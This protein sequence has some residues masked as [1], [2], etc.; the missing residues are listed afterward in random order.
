MRIVFMGTP[1]FAV[2]SLKEL[3]NSKN[4]ICAVVTSPD[5]PAGRGLQLKES[6]VKKFAKTINVPI[7]QPTNLKDIN[8][9]NELKSYNADIFVVVAFRMLPEIVW[10]IPPKGTINLHASLL[11][12]YRGAAPINWAIINGEKLTGVTTFFIEK[13]IDVGKIIDFEEV[14]I[15]E[16]DDAGILH[17]KLMIAGAKLLTKTINNIQENNFDPINQQQFIIPNKLL[18]TAPKLNRETNKIN[19]SLNCKNIFN[20]IRGLSPY[21]TAWTIFENKLTNENITVKIFSSEIIE[22]KHNAKAGTIISD[23]K[24]Y[25][26]ISGI[27]GIISI[28]DIQPEGRKKMGIKNFLAGFRDIENWIALS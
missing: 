8:F 12:N 14:K 3:I 23:N 22:G 20:K 21:P 6:D 17:D 10:Q 7:L 28:F 26:Y 13:E 15:T 4:K 16:K 24:N 25:L 27:D 1:E 11:P 5:K 9:I 19:W 18:K 2:E